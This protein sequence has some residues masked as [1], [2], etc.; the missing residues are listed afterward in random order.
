MSN[1]ERWVPPPVSDDPDEDD[2]TTPWASPLDAKVPDLPPPDRSAPSAAVPPAAAPAAAQPAG[3]KPAGTKKKLWI[4]GCGGC[5]FLLLSICCCS[6]YV[7]YL[8]EGVSYEDPGEELERYPIGQGQ[9]IDVHHTWEGTGYADLR[10]YV[11]VGDAPPGTL[12]EG[13]FKCSE[14]GE[15]QPERVSVAPSV[16]GDV[17]EGWA[18]MPGTYLYVRDGD[19]VRCTG[20]LRTQP[21]G[22]SLELV[23]TERQRPSDVL[24]F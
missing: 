1:D 6:G 17:P 16:G 7:L 10:A 19:T 21:P 5:L 13:R 22:A 20:E 8:E 11:D 12:V 14:Y 24:A 4:A 18:Q 2:L 15:P 3:T 23:L 9:P